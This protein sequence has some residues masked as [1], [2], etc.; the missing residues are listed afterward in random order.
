MQ[1]FEKGKGELRRKWSALRD[2]ISDRTEKS[3]EI[4]RRLLA[5]SEVREAKTILIYLSFRSE[6]D[7]HALL[8]KLLETEK[9]VAVPLCNPKTHTL[10]GVVI[11]S[12]TDLKPG[13]YGILEPNRE[14]LSTGGF[15]ILSKDEVDL[16]LVPGLAFDREG[17]RLGYGGGY[18]DR[19]LRDFS[20]SSIGVAFSE[21]IT[22]TLPRTIYDIPVN[23][24]V[25][26]LEYF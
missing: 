6:P 10:C 23:R 21:C 26:E 13:H 15:T 20:G 9:R 11:E 5:I 2:S 22:E 8:Q 4:C 25:T 16:V 19:Y 17:F 3:A 1:K 12:F 7:T 24:V 14:K 18:Y